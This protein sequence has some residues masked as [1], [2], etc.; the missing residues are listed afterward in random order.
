[1]GGV[2]GDGHGHREIKTVDLIGLRDADAGAETLKIVIQAGSLTAENQGKRRLEI[3][4]GE[5]GG[6]RGHEGIQAAGKLLLVIPETVEVLKIYPEDRSH[7]S[8]DGFGI[9]DIS[10]RFDNCQVGEI[11]SQHGPADGAQITHVPDTYQDQM[12]LVRADPAGVFFKYPD[13]ITVFLGADP[14]NQ[15]V[16]GFNGKTFLAAQGGDFIYPGIFG[17]LGAY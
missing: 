1:M 16:G 12:V 8:P 9:K 10:G 13:G 7:G 5:R 6:T 15:A 11:K 17:R 14:V 4:A 2:E 3:D